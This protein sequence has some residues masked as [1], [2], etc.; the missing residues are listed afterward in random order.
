MREARSITCSY[1]S[2]V[3]MTTSITFMPLSSISMASASPSLS[4]VLFLDT[5]RRSSLRFGSLKSSPHS[6][7]HLG[8]LPEL[9]SHLYPHDLQEQW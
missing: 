8:C 7:Q 2:P 3:F 4:S 1:E 6:G 5:L 9:S